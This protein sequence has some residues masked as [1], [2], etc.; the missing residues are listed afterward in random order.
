MSPRRVAGARSNRISQREKDHIMA[1]DIT[2]YLRSEEGK[3]KGGHTRAVGET[4]W[5]KIDA[6]TA[7]NAGGRGDP[8]YNTQIGSHGPAP[9]RPLEPS[10]SEG[11]PK[12]LKTA[13]APTPRVAAQPAGMKG[14]R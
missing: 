9:S 10:A 7:K 6:A 13:G 11:N 4:G 8:A 3:R 5:G 14:R 1:G 2:E 12:G